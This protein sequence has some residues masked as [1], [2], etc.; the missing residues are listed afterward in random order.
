M[1]KGDPALHLRV[2]N[3][4]EGLRLTLYSVA[5]P[6]T[7]FIYSAADSVV[8]HR[9]PIEFGTDELFI[10]TVEAARVVDD[11]RALEITVKVPKN[12]PGRAEMARFLSGAE[13]WAD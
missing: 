5:E 4:D 8:G 11:G 9:I 12:A 2:E 3:D 13:H 1:P 7:R 6:G 10:G